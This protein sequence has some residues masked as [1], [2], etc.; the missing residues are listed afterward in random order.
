MRRH[1]SLALL[2]LVFMHCSLET[3]LNFETLKIGE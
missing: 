1:L 2:A 3:E